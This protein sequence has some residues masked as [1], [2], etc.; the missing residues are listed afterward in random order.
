MVEYAYGAVLNKAGKTGYVNF[1]MNITPDCDCVPWSDA[2]IVPDIGFLASTDPVAIDTASCDLINQQHGLSGTS[3]HHH[4][5][6]GEDKFTGVWEKVNGYHLLEYA[7]QIGMGS[8][9]YTLKEI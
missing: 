1:L 6:P 2:P 9:S 7:E 4:H 3:L 8:R 5:E